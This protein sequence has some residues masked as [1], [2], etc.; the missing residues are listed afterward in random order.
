MLKSYHQRGTHTFTIKSFGDCL[1]HPVV[2]ITFPPDPTVDLLWDVLWAMVQKRLHPARFVGQMILSKL[3]ESWNRRTS[4]NDLNI[5][6]LN[7]PLDS[8][9]I[10]MHPAKIGWKHPEGKHTTYSLYCMIISIISLHVH[11]SQYNSSK[12]ISTQTSRYKVQRKKVASTHLDIADHPQPLFS[13]CPG[14]HAHKQHPSIPE[15]ADLVVTIST[16]SIHKEML[17]R[18]LGKFHLRKL[19]P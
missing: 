16:P 11:K 15:T 5:S 14:G 19:P 6:K 8:W 18:R 1:V 10:A 4:L 3:V 2:P 9:V 7:H 13:A 12:Y 17:V